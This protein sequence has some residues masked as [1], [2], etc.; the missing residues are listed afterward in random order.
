MDVTTMNPAHLVVASATGMSDSTGKVV[1]V[2]AI[3]AGARDMI[4]HSQSLLNSTEVLDTVVKKYT[5]DKNS[6]SIPDDGTHNIPDP[7]THPDEFWDLTSINEWIGK[8]A[9]KI[10]TGTGE[11]D[12][13]KN[14]QINAYVNAWNNWATLQTTQ[15]DAASGEINSWTKTEQSKVSEAQSNIQAM[16]GLTQAAIGTATSGAN[17]ISQPM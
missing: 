4:A 15:K 7:T 6:P 14:A 3:S 10:T 8:L 11:E 12:K 16:G 1:M 2:G 5:G 9:K 13:A 17:M